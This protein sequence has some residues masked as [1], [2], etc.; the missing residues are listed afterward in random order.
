MDTPAS[1]TKGSRVQRNRIMQAVNLGN[2]E[3]LKRQLKNPAGGSIHD[4]TA[5]VRSPFAF[6]VVPSFRCFDRVCV[7]ASQRMQAGSTALHMACSR[8]SVECVQILLEA[9][10]D[11][12]AKDDVRSRARC[13]LFAVRA[14]TR[15]CRCAH[16]W[17]KLRSCCAAA[18]LRR[19]PQSA[20][21]YCS[22]LA[23]SL[24]PRTH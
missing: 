9:N 1:A 7:C 4:A 6:V 23:L 13:R 12:N 20:Q 11:V 5:A 18:S 10:A 2:V 21:S 22:L 19:T 16:S 15:A 14:D 3:D 8:A 17:A 24:C